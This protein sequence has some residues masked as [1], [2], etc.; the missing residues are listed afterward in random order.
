M[1]LRVETDLHLLWHSLS[2]VPDPHVFMSKGPSPL[3]SVRGVYGAFSTTLRMH[4]YCKS[5]LLNQ[6]KDEQ[7]GEGSGRGK[8]PDLIMKSTQ[9]S[10]NYNFILECKRKLCDHQP[11]RRLR[12]ALV[13][14]VEK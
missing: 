4:E 8:S 6:E 3:C 13:D 2:P 10:Y 11:C 14:E 1:I 5:T 9:A 7:E 12:N